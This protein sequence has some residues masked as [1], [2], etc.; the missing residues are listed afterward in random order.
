[1]A[2]ENTRSDGDSCYFCGEKEGI[3][4]H[5]ILPQRFDGSERESNVVDLCH[6]CH[7]KLE[8]LYNKDFWDAVGVED[9]RSTK[10]THLTC[11]YHKC[12]NQAVGDFRTTAGTLTYRCE[13][14][15]PSNSVENSELRSING[16]DQEFINK[17][18]SQLELI[19]Q[20]QK[21]MIPYQPNKDISDGRE[22]EKLDH[23]VALVHDSSHTFKVQREDGEWSVS[24]E[25]YR[26]PD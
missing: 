23:D 5:H 10:E 6:D 24:Y 21:H 12:L 14:H 19:C 16:A 22:W 20:H 26:E 11:D 2:T 18:I 4:Q 7:W 15:K 25:G 8:R 1:M 13:E 9:P 17:T 3:E